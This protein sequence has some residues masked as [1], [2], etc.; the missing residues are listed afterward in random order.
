MIAWSSLLGLM[1]V[2][3]L[4]DL[5]RLWADLAR[6]DAPT[7][8]RAVWSLVD[9]PAQAVPFL[10]GKLCRPDRRGDSG[11][12]PGLIADLDADDFARRQRAHRE[13]DRLGKA[14]V[15]ALRAALARKPSLEVV[16]RI[17]RLLRVHD[18]PSV[19]VPAGDALRGVRAVQVLEVIG[20]SEARKVL[21]ALQDGPPTALSAEARKALER[22]DRRTRTRR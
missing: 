4:A 5:E 15:P 9:R 16:Q 7:G 1:M 12:L 3:D 18:V 10:R 2:V 8:Q 11:R 13:L 6:P 21:L 19:L 14:A 20:T 17:E 22:L